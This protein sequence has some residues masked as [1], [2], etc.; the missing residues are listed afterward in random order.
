[1]VHVSRNNSHEHR[2]KREKMCDVF[3]R[4]P[5]AFRRGMV[6]FEISVISNVDQAQLFGA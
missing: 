1:M 3:W 5:V 6:N 2:L 4:K